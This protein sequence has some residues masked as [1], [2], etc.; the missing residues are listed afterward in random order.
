MIGGLSVAIAENRTTRELTQKG[1]SNSALTRKPESRS[2]H[3][4][5]Q[6]R[7]SVWS[8]GWSF[9]GHDLFNDA[10]RRLGLIEAA[11]TSYMVA[12]RIL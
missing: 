6:E 10:T 9:D 2:R 7:R 5:I 12:T 8:N 1:G 4:R 3:G 11:F